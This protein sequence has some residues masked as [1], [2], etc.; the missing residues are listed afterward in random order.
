MYTKPCML[1]GLAPGLGS[2]HKIFFCP[3]PR[4]AWGTYQNSMNPSM[5]TSR[6]RRSILMLPNRYWGQW[7]QC[8]KLVAMKMML[9]QDLLTLCID[10]FSR[11]LLFCSTLFDTVCVEQPPKR[12]IWHVFDTGCVELTLFQ[13]HFTLFSIVLLW[14]DWCFLFGRRTIRDRSLFIKWRCWVYLG[15]LGMSEV[16]CQI[17]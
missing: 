8:L 10:F 12:S 16:I 6:Y 14:P 4:A 9:W 11:F 2:A 5:G 3:T 7:V 13:S 1:S 15:I 17:L